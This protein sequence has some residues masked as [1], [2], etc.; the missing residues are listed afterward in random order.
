MVN[1]SVYASLS[2]SNPNQVIVVAINK[3]SATVTAGIRLA[4]PKTLASS[5]VYVLAGSKADLVAG[6]A[7]DAAGANAFTY[8]MPARSVSVLVFASSGPSPVGGVDGGPL[9]SAPAGDDAGVDV[10]D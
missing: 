8:A 9:D 2:S 3:K 6:A 10:S 1:T 5:K 4:H 7:P